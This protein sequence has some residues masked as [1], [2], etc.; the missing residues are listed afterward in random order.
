MAEEGT[1][2]TNED[3][4]KKAG[5]NVS[6]TAKGEDYTNVYIQEAEGWIMSQ[7]KKE[8]LVSN[9]SNLSD[10]VKQLLQNI[11]SNIAAIYV[12]NYDQSGFS[13][14]SDVDIRIQTLW[15]TTKE[16]MK[17]LNEILIKT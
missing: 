4:K 15:G 14:R 1:F 13:R 12:L 17:S 6:S 8:D 9:Y 11:S 2:C 3:V 10:A 5:D 7:V 16:A